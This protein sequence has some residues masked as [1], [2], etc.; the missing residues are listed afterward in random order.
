[1]RRYEDKSFMPQ[2]NSLSVPFPTQNVP[3]IVTEHSSEGE[4]DDSENQI[5][6]RMRISLLAYLEWLT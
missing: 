3:G 4:R 2:N 1:M 6:S 5:L